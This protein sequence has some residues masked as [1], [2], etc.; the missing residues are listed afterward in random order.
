[1]TLK[2][3]Y[4]PQVEA[5]KVGRALITPERL[6]TLNL[7]LSSG[8]LIYAAI[9]FFT[10]LHQLFDLNGSDFMLTISVFYGAI[11]YF[12]ISCLIWLIVM[13]DI[14]PVQSE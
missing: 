5:T 8:L 12:G 11:L 10:H 9:D 7:I 6:L 1:M 13:P 4:S 14:P 2:Q 3:D